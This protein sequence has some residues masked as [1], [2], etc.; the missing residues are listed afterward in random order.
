M[1]ISWGRLS[2][3]YHPDRFDIVADLIL[4]L[5]FGLGFGLALVHGLGHWPM[6][7]VMAMLAGL[8]GATG[9]LLM[10]MFTSS[11]RLKMLMFLGG[12]LALPTFYDFTFGY[13]DNVHFVTLTNGYPINIAEVIF[14]P[15]MA[16][17][18]Y[19]RLT[20][21][22]PPPLRYPSGWTV[23]LVLLGINIYSASFVAVEPFFSYSMIFLQ[24]K[25]Y[26][27]LVF[28]AN[29]VR[30]AQTLRLACYAFAGVLLFEGFVVFEQ[31]SIGVIFTAENLGRKIQ[32]VSK[33]GMDK[34]E[35]VSGTLGHPNALAM[36][37]N[38]ILPW[39]IFQFL[40]EKHWK[41]RTYLL[42][43][44]LTAI[45]VE[46][47]T[48]SRGAWM[49]F[50]LMMGIGMVFWMHKNGKNILVGMG[51]AGFIGITLFTIAFAT[52]STFRLRV[53]EGDQASAEVRVPL[54]DVAKE[55]IA[56]HPLTGVGLDNYTRWMALYDRTTYRVATNYDQPVHNTYLLMAAETGVLALVLFLW[57]IARQIWAAFWLFI[58]SRGPPATLGLGLFCALF[59]W[60]IHNQ[61]NLTAPFAD[62]TLWVLVGLLTAARH[63]PPEGLHDRP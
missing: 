25:S 20:T 53:V 48:G 17:W 16:L 39:V 40:E 59:V 63:L 38:L 60:L 33:A 7:W 49:G 18:F 12:I 24:I 2:Q 34:I 4:P 42:G 41:I 61:V 8:C 58:Q 27:L 6:K 28:I 36:Y 32:L 9:M 62:E 30:D 55:M 44:I 1:R 13:R 51:V 45:F 26:L 37:L 10:A 43:A 5:A 47:L 15:L 11:N 57:V 35:R 19:E 22:H 29:Y 50:G 46:M 52:S 23:L 31:K 21:L 54:M 56:N 14:F 3:A